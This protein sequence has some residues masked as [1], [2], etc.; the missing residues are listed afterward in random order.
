[1]FNTIRDRFNWQSRKTRLGV[2][3]AVCAAGLAI[4]LGG[5][6]ML[7]NVTL[8]APPPSCTT[9][10]QYKVSMA[11]CPSGPLAVG[12]TIC[13]CCTNGQPPSGV[14]GGVILFVKGTNCDVQVISWNS[15]CS[16]CSGG[17]QG[18]AVN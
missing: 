1:M 13:I 15:S 11:S 12:D 8:E 6:V 17:D 4:G 5:S 9:F 10:A 7:A 16:S 2:A 14:T 18:F 3:A